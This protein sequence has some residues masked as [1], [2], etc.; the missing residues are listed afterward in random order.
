M[1]DK[2]TPI[3][4]TSTGCCLH[5]KQYGEIL[6]RDRMF[7]EKAQIVSSLVRDP[8]ECIQTE[9]LKAEIVAMDPLEKAH[10][11]SPCTLQHGQNLKGRVEDLLV[12]LGF[13]IWTGSES[14][15]CCGSAGTYSLFHPETARALRD[16]KL[17]DLEHQR[18]AFIV[19]ANIGCQIH[20]GLGT[21]TP[22]LH[23]LELLQRKLRPDGEP[24][25]NLQV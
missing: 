5:L 7:G 10:F 25:E 3:V 21:H 15:M 17:T 20:L 12:E 9:Q 24:N 22:V 16:R 2:K 23:W 19:T 18:A 1:K 6:A 4:A 14:H 11:Q 13:Q 8:I